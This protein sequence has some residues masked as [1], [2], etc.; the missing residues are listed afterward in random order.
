MTDGMKEYIVNSLCTGENTTA[1]R[2][3]TLICQLVDDKLISGPV[4][5]KSQG[6]DFVKNWRR[7]N[8]KDSMAPLIALRDGSGD[9][10]LVSRLG[11]GSKF[12]PLRV[13]ITYLQCFLDYIVVQNRSD[14][15]TILHIDSTHS[16]VI[17]DYVVFAFGYS[18]RSGHFFP[19]IYFCTSQKRAIDIGWCIRYTKRVCLD[20]CG[21]VLA[22]QFVMMEADKAQFNACVTELPHSIVLM[23]WFHVTKNVW[24]KAQAFKVESNYAVNSP[25]RKLIEHVTKLWV[26]SHRFSRWQT[27]RTPRGYAV[28]NNPLEQYHRTVKIQCHKGKASPSELMKN[29]DGARLAALNDDVQ[30]ASVATASDRLMRLYRLMHKRGCLV[31]DRLPPVGS[32]EADLY[33]V[34]QSGLRLTS[35]EQN[36][37]QH[38]FGQ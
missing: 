2:L 24:K 1:A 22:S 32:V 4:P 16:M 12:Y 14:C 5:K 23:C 29:L 11:D 38:L 30:F 7:K 3:Y 6:A 28:T 8:P 26:N 31:V 15:T 20:A 10:D 37:S 33:R 19:L 9:R 13:G 27:F 34:K 21:I 35:A 25:L 18:D 36:W 17:N